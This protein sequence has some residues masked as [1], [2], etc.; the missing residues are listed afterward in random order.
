VWDASAKIHYN[1]GRQ[2]FGHELM[3]LLTEHDSEGYLA[4]E[5]EARSAATN[6]KLEA[7]AVQAR[8]GNGGSNG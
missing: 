1:A 3:A 5:R 8:S 7:E 6:E 4:M 2:D